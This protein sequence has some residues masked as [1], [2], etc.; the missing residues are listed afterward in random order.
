[1]FLNVYYFNILAVTASTST[2]VYSSDILSK[3]STVEISIPPQDE[4][5][6]GKH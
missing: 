6:F 1:M 2:T 5:S 4:N 3:M